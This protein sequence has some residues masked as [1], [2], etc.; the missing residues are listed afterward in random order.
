MSELSV[1]MSR[2]LRVGRIIGHVAWWIF[3]V[4]RTVGGVSGSAGLPRRYTSYIPLTSTDDGWSAYMPTAPMDGFTDANILATLSMIALAVTIL[5][6][7]AEAI[8][9]R[10]WLAS[11]LTI[12][13]P[14]VGAALVMLAIDAQDGLVW[15]GVYLRPV[16]V[17][18][19]IMLG[20][21]VREIWSRGFAPA[22]R[23]SPQL[24]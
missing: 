9:Y 21:A 18:S 7:V 15:D 16:L 22:A 8:T 6:A 23:R 14:V 2:G 13:A 3:V 24:D 5:A 17:A 1:T 4:T 12:A 19:L 20:V 10:S 11:S